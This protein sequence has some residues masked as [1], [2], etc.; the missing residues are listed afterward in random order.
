MKTTSRCGLG[1]T[2]SNCLLLSLDKFSDYFT[3]RFSA[4]DNSMY[5]AFDHRAAVAEYEHYKP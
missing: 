5:R 4:T 3:E 2:A 1:K